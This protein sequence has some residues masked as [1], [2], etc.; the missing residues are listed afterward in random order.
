MSGKLSAGGPIHHHVEFDLAEILP[1][2][3]SGPHARDHGAGFGAVPDQVDLAVGDQAFHHQHPVELGADGHDVVG[4]RE[5]LVG[6]ADIRRGD[7]GVAAGKQD[8]R[9]GGDEQ[10]QQ[11]NVQIRAGHVTKVLTRRRLPNPTFARCPTPILFL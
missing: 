10:K 4:G 7:G 6:F 3:S 2:M 11:E 5:A 1:R 8:G 9:G